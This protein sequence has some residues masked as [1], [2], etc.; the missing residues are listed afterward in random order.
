MQ[1]LFKRGIALGAYPAQDGRA[2]LGLGACRVSDCH[3]LLLQRRRFWPTELICPA[4]I[5]LFEQ[6]AQPEYNKPA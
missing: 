6:T 1:N 5:L 2:A 4:R 3:T